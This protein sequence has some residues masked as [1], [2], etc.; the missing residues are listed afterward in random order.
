M[1]QLFKIINM[2]SK[3]VPPPFPVKSPEIFCSILVPWQKSQLLLRQALVW[4]WKWECGR[5]EQI[6]LFLFLII[7][8][9]LLLAIRSVLKCISGQNISRTGGQSLVWIEDMNILWFFLWIPYFPIYFPRKLFFLT[10]EIG[11]NSNI[12]R[13]IWIPYLINGIFAAETI[14][15]WKLYEEIQYIFLSSIYI[16]GIRIT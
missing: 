7:Y 3:K 14:Q 5:P 11:A 10:L 8:F 4:K 9:S 1:G 13:N 15:G 2:L 6:W 16:R 12:C